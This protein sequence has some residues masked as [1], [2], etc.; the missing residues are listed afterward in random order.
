MEEIILFIYFISLSAVT[1]RNMFFGQNIRSFQCFCV[2]FEPTV[3]FLRRSTRTQHTFKRWVHKP[4]VQR[5]WMLPE[6]LGI[7]DAYVPPSRSS[8]PVFWRAPAQRMRLIW[9]WLY[10]RMKGWFERKL[11][12]E[13]IRPIKIDFKQLHVTVG[14]IYEK[15]N[16][17]YAKGDFKEIALFCSPAYTQTLKSQILKRPADFELKWQLHKMIKPPKLVSFSH[18]KVELDSNKYL[19]QAI[20]RIHSEQSLT[21]FFD[22]LEKKGSPKILVEYY[23][24]QYKTWV[25]PYK[26]YIWGK[27]TEA[28]PD[29]VKV[30]IWKKDDN[31]LKT[32]RF[33]CNRS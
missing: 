11:F 8:L 24:F 31:M 32:V 23:V 19:A 14:K 33:L 18:A 4:L 16:Q 9:R 30:K 22:G 5:Q 13:S 27:T 29:S 3:L 26:W 7:L 2:F 21:T 20:Y 1:S 12:E 10:H 15:V 17:A 28:S 6:D 25:R